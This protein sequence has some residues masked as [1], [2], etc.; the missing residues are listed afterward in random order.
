MLKWTTALLPLTASLA[1]AASEPLVVQRID[2]RLFQHH[3]GT[4]SEP[5]T[6][7]DELWNTI[8]GE[9]VANGPSTATVV[10]VVVSGA[11]DT[12]DPDWQVEF[13]AREKGSGEVVLT[14]SK[15]VGVLDP[16]GMYHVGFWLEGTGCTALEVRARIGAAARWA[17]SE[18]PFACGE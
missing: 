17:Q 8:L 9:G 5:I 11:P 10:D 14:Q 1:M 2:V 12:F 15:S 4:L 18:I 3:S 6:K 7:Q 16:D 13:I